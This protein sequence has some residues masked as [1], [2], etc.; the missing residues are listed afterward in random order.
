MKQR[1][2]RRNRRQLDTFDRL[3]MGGAYDPSDFGLE[4]DERDAY[5]L[6]TKSVFYQN[7]QEEEEQLSELFGKNARI[8]ARLYDQEE[9][10][11]ECEDVDP[12]VY[13]D[14]CDDMGD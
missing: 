3:T 8:L 10:E 5:N 6:H 9:C 7:D 4:L 14:D 12:I 11:E 13:D 2:Q 1:K